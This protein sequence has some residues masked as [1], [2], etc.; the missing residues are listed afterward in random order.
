MIPYS[1]FMAV[2]LISGS[3][4]T[5]IICGLDLLIHSPL[6][7]F[8]ARNAPQ[9]H[10][11][12][13]VTALAIFLFSAS[14]VFLEPT[15]ESFILC[16]ALNFALLVIHTLDQVIFEARRDL[17]PLE[18]ACHSWQLLCGALGIG[19]YTGW[20]L[21]VWHELGT[22][23]HGWVMRDFGPWAWSYV[24]LVVVTGIGLFTHGAE[25]Y[26]AS[27]YPTKINERWQWPLKKVLLS[28]IFWMP[29]KK[30]EDVRE[31]RKAAGSGR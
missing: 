14:A 4:M 26:I 17:P 5:A 22:V 31:L 6:V 18:A 13:Y 27:R 30:E 9:E 12:H 24:P 20:V 23:P 11:N 15:L 29:E 7:L 28:P 2:A 1:E 21:A 19:L 10:K 3:W 8:L 25:M 16:I